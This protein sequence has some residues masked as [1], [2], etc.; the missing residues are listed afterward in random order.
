MRVG[1]R[2]PSV[3]R[4][5][6]NGKSVS[7]SSPG[8][9][10][11][12]LNFWATWCEPCRE[13][14]PTFAR[15]QSAMKKQGLRVVGVSMDDDA[16]AVKAFLA[17]YPVTYSIVMGDAKFAEQFGGVLGLPLTY[18]IDPEGRVVARYQGEAD[19]RKMQ[20]KIQSLLR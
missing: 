18:L 17:R 10:L 13:E 2:I 14:I 16:A 8:K 11:L 4:A 12:L 6:I 9:G 15:W 3:V 7:L 20:E 5:D 1:D 19:L